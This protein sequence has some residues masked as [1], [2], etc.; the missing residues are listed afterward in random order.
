MPLSDPGALVESVPR[1]A[2]C[3][4]ALIKAAAA[5]SEGAPAPPHGRF[6][7]FLW[8]FVGGAPK[9]NAWPSA[10]DIPSESAEAVALAKELK[11]RGFAFVGPKCCYSLLQSCGLVIDHPA[12]TPERKEA[13]RRLR[14]RT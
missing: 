6:D 3:V 12:G 4:L 9:L 5:A 7:A 8:S 2:R 10:N 13:C 14:A 11:A 1:N